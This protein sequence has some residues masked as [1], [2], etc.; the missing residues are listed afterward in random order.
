MLMPGIAVLSVST[1][2]GHSGSFSTAP[3]HEKAV[4]NF[5]LILEQHKPECKESGEL[6]VGP[7]RVRVRHPMPGLAIELQSAGPGRRRGF[8]R[9]PPLL[10]QSLATVPHDGKI[11]G[12][13][14]D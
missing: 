5:L 13:V 2:L 12:W 3:K 8:P 10:S 1:D 7:Q 14:G 9:P 4:L 11:T 6:D